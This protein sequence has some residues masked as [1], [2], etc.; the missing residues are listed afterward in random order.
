MKLAKLFPSLVA[1]LLIFALSVPKVDAAFKDV[2][3]TYWASDIINEFVEAGIISGYEDETF[4]PGNTVTREQ[5]AI[6]ISRALKLDTTNVKPVNY[7]DIKESDNAYKA[8]AAVTNAGIMIGVDGKFEPKQPITRVQLATILTK[9]FDLKGNGTSLFKDVPKNHSAY[10]TIDALYANKIALGYT[11]GAFKPEKPTTRAEFIAFLDRALNLKEQNTTEPETETETGTENESESVADLL[12]EVYANEQNL[13]SYEFNGKVNLG[14]LFPESAVTTPEDKA[15]FDMLKDINVEISGAYQKDP[16]RFEANIDVTIKGDVQTTFT[17]PMVMTEDKI[18]VKLPN[19]PL[20]PLPQEFQGKFIELN[21]Q[22]LTQMAGQPS[23]ALDMNLQT[24][25]GMDIINLFVDLLGNDFYKEVALDSVVVPTGVEGDKVIKF[26]VTNETL[27]PF[28]NVVF[29][30]LLP[31]MFELIAQNPEYVKALGFTPEDIALTKDLF[32]SEEFNLDEVVSE[33]NKFLTINQFDEHIVITQDNY[34]GYDVVNVDITMTM[35][36]ETLGLKL[37]FDQSKSKV[38][39][40][41]KFPIG[42]PSGDN[43]IPFE[44]LMEMEQQALNTESK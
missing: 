30:E 43:V 44:K 33:I 23:S 7:S 18:W 15:V 22:Q 12:K 42:I 16:M 2:R 21:L 19:S 17:I 27:K 4:R 20:L 6:I 13:S 8:I 29:D 10:N 28:V 37:F 35:E 24:K 41:I 34:I 5:A 40:Q 11:N 39:E 25:L 26:E 1:F 31:Q 14:I 38:N 36:G 3:D 9:S 32:S